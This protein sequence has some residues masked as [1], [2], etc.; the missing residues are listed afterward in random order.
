MNL[1][2]K[3]AL[4][5]TGYALRIADARLLAGRVWQAIQSVNDGKF[6]KVRGGL[7]GHA[8]D[9]QGTIVVRGGISAA[10]IVGF[11]E[12]AIGDGASGVFPRNSGEKSRQALQGKFLFLDIFRFEDAVR[13]KN[14]HVAS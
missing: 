6:R 5:G 3:V 14:Y 8:E 7:I 13:S 10:V 9:D 12:D 11:S 2:G 4:R 1:G